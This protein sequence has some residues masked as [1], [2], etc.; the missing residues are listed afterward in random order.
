ML[1]DTSTAEKM[2]EELLDYTYEACRPLGYPVSYRVAESQQPLPF[3][4]NQAESTVLPFRRGLH[5]LHDTHPRTE[6][7]VRPGRFQMQNRRYLGNKYKLLEFIEDIIR[8]KCPDYKVFCDIFSGTGVVAG[9]FNRKNTVVIANDLLLSNYISLKAFLETSE[10]DY[11]SMERKI[12]LLNGI[13]AKD[14]NYS[15]YNFGGRYFTMENARKIGAIREKIEEFSEND[16]EKAI[17]IVSL[18]YAVDKV[19]NTVGHYDAFRKNLDMVQPL[20][21]L[22]PDIKTNDNANNMAFNEDANLLAREISCDVLYADP[23]YNSRQYSDA[24]HLL[25]NLASW[26]KPPVYGKANKMDR[27]HIK[28]AYCLRSAEDAFA[29]LIAHAKCRHIL[30][31]YNNTGESKDGRSN[32]RISDSDILRILKDK[33]DVEVFERNYKAFTTGRSDTTG[34]TERIF[35]CRV[36]S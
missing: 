23:P 14:D 26:D 16:G 13:E 24:Y 3:S 7:R 35:Y 4:R 25:E 32:A 11:E 18:I 20:N 6:Q 8:Q 31:S 9:H 17:L 19:A 28:S 22:M 12:S 36:K 5:S 30:L 2:E 33:G 10:I 29:D 27:K 34:H 1:K 15:S 21:L